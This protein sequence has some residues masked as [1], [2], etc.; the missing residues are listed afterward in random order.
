MDSTGQRSLLQ[1]LRPWGTLQSCLCPAEERAGRNCGGALASPCPGCAAVRVGATPYTPTHST[2]GPAQPNPRCAH[3]ASRLRAEGWPSMA[4]AGEATQWSRAAWAQQSRWDCFMP[5]AI[6]GAAVSQPRRARPRQHAF[7]H[8]SSTAG[9]R[10]GRFLPP[11]IRPPAHAPTNRSLARPPTDPPTADTHPPTWDRMSQTALV[12]VSR[13]QTKFLKESKAE[14]R[15]T[16]A[17]QRAWA[18]AAWR[19]RSNACARKEMYC[20]VASQ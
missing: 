9:K 17:A 16:C 18:C 10:G 2:A 19:G 20:A 6:G 11:S 7:A 8:R 15:T 5:G 13:H 14:G 12:T 4:E 1:G 3:R